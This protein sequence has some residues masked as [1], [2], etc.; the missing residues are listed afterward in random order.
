VKSFARKK[1]AKGI[2]PHGEEYGKKNSIHHRRMVF[3]LKE[4]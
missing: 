3:V 1:K 2:S 4:E